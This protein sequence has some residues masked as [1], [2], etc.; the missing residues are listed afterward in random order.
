M[1]ANFYVRMGVPSL[2]ELIHD[3][4]NI[5]RIVWEYDVNTRFFIFFHHPPPK[6]HH[7]YVTL[8]MLNWDIVGHA[9]GLE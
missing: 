6:A 3:L 2:E 1:K 9:I 7:I 4:G 8:E 5:S